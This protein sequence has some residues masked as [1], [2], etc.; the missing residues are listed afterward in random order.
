MILL[1]FFVREPC[2]QHQ[3][4][5]ILLH[6]FVVEP[7]QQTSTSS[8]YVLLQLIVTEPCN[9]HQVY[10]GI[11]PCF[12]LEAKLTGSISKPQCVSFWKF[13]FLNCS[14]RLG[15]GTYRE[16]KWHACLYV[17][18]YGYLESRNA[19]G[20]WISSI[21][22]LEITCWCLHLPYQTPRICRV[23]VLLF[24]WI[25]MTHSTLKSQQIRYTK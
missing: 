3:F 12:S 8:L 24:E 20:S 16:L 22:A 4:Y 5:F 15:V 7:C 9:K 13:W 21:S 19:R 14:S 2:F 23:F 1:Q 18:V 11:A 25:K 10:L 6:L 17:K